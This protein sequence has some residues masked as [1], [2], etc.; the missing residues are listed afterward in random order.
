[1]ILHNFVKMLTQIYNFIKIESQ[2]V[3]HPSLLAVFSPLAEVA[4]PPGG[5]KADPKADDEYDRDAHAKEHPYHSFSRQLLTIRV[6]VAAFLLSHLHSA[7]AR[8]PSLKSQITVFRPMQ[9]G[10]CLFSSRHI[11]S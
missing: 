8:C 3:T 6:W 5:P 4:G 11:S 2:F 10:P 9:S 1:M 7:P